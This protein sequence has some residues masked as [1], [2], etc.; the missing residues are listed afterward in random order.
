MVNLNEIFEK[1]EFLTAAQKVSIKWIHDEIISHHSL[2]D[3]EG[4]EFKRFEVVSFGPGRSAF[5]VSEYGMVGDE[6]T[7]A[8]IFCR[9]YRNFEVKKFGKVI[10]SNTAK[11]VKGEKVL[12]KVKATGHKAMYWYT[13]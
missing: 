13:C 7:M 1:A 8:S 5:L 2:G 9:D 6:D 12:A 4:H 11:I 10:L 3:P